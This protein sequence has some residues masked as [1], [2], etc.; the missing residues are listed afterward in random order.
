VRNLIFPRF[1]LQALSPL[2]ADFFYHVGKVEVQ[3]RQMGRALTTLL[4]TFQNIVNA[5]NNSNG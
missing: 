3:V 2:F 1:L 4:D 5:A